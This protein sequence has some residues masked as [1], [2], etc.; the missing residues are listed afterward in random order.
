MKKLF[1]YLIIGIMVLG[2][3]GAATFLSKSE[4]LSYFTT[5]KAQREGTIKNAITTIVFTKDAECKIDYTSERITCDICYYFI[6][7]GEERYNCIGINE[8][9][10]EKM[11]YDTVKSAVKMRIA[12]IEPIEDVKFTTIKMKDKS[13][14]LT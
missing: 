9:D 13:T 14:S 3:V 6:Y 7:K 4:A 2:L 10:T 8:D 11:I 12:D 1:V 5:Y